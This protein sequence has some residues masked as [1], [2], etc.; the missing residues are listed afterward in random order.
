MGVGLSD[1]IYELEPPYV[2]AGRRFKNRATGAQYQI[3]ARLGEGGFGSVH[4]CHIVGSESSELA[5]KLTLNQESWVREVY[6][7]LLVEN[8]E[9]A[10]HV[11]D[12]FPV[13]QIDG[14]GRPGFVVVMDLAK[15]GDLY[16]FLSDP[17]NNLTEVQ[18]VS[19]ARRLLKTLSHLHEG[20]AVH[21]DLTPKN[22][23]FDENRKPLLGDF[24]IARHKGRG[25]APYASA[26]N[27]G[28]CPPEVLR[29]YGWRWSARQDIWQVGQLLAEMLQ[30][31]PHTIIK[32]GE[33]RSLNCSAWLA[34]VIYRA[35][36]PEAERYSSANDMLV[37]MKEKTLA[38]ETLPRARPT[39]IAGKRLVFTARI[40]AFPRHEAS[41]RAKDVGA[42]VQDDVTHGT[43]FLVIGGSSPAYAAD[44]AGTKIM[45]ALALNQ[46]GADIRTI[47]GDQF[48]KMV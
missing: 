36:G 37:A 15:G 5:A 30:H 16:T 25:P 18:V 41:R 45:R 13:A 42:I 19:I 32:P 22:V 9:G 8:I 31:D 44:T 29:H 43:D 39:S 28:Y 11:H 35:I 40:S 17:D 23:F 26:F 6:F 34:E 14:S 10:I 38:L 46:E 2:R 3:G 12:A 33:V 47:T 27:Y 48:T 4:K 7:G 20:S 1:F 24:G 21:R